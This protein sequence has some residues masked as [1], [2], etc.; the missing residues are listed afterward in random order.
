MASRRDRLA[1]RRIALGYSQEGFAD[2]CG[3]ATSTVVRWEAGRATPHPHQRPKMARLL[4]LTPEELDTVLAVTSESTVAPEQHL[5]LSVDGDTDDMLRREVLALIA[6]TGAVISVPSELAA[7]AGSRP[8]TSSDAGQFL[9]QQF[10]SAGSKRDAM[11]LV[12]QRISRLADGLTGPNTEAE[13][14]F[15][16]QQVADLYQLAGEILFDMNRYADAAQCY[17]LA[18]SAAREVKAHD[19]WACSLTRQAFTHLYGRRPAT[20]LPLLGAAARVAA[21]GDPQL[22]TRYWVASVQAEAYA[23]LG[24]VDACTRAL[25]HAERVHD[26]VGEVHNGG[27]L[28]FDGSRLAEQRGLCHLALGQ[29]DVAERYLSTAVRQ[30]LSARRQGAVL[31]DLAELGARHRDVDGVVHYGSAALALAERTRSGYIARRLEGLRG[32]LAP[33]MSDPRISN[34]TEQITYRGAS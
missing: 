20:A 7:S 14:A 33:L 26:L 27:W 2:G 32:T 17:T 28:R 9:W 13:Q 21:R 34:L 8:E 29:T 1:E 11:T 24:D 12:R 30:G 19:L 18:A 10:R 23:G 15:L 4:E 22:S 6:A 31:A 3:V 5:S 16:C 25:D